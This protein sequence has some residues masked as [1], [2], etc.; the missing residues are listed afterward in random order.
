MQTV[1]VLDSSFGSNFPFFSAMDKEEEKDVKQDDL[2]IRSQTPGIAQASSQYLEN[3]MS[4]SP[5]SILKKPSTANV[6]SRK[7]VH[8]NL[9]IKYHKNPS[10]STFNSPEIKDINQSSYFT[11]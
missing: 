9:R 10:V 7:Q 8:Y 1:K 5:K 6:G 3:M 2:I 11:R 4:S